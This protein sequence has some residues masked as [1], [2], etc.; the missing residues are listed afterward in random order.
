MI[1]TGSRQVVA[2]LM[3]AEEAAE[4]LRNRDDRKRLAE[5]FWAMVDETAE[6]L[7]KRRAT[8][9]PTPQGSDGASGPSNT[10]PIGPLSHGDGGTSKIQGA[11]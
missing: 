9:P 6:S 2:V 11:E 1:P 7:R 3:T 8:E 5:G 4:W 10:R